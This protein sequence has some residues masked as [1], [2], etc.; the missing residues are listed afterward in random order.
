MIPERT[1]DASSARK[2]A[3]TR[4]RS[5]HLAACSGTSSS[6]GVTS[7]PTEPGAVTQPGSIGAIPAAGTPSG[8]AGTITYA[9]Q[10]GAVPNWILP[11]PAAAS[12]SVY[13]VF[14]FEWQ[15][16]PPMY[17]APNGST[18]TVDPSL[19]V[20]NPPTR[21]PPRR[22]QRTRPAGRSLTSPMRPMRPR[23]SPT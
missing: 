10:P 22:G 1:G 3:M 21:C 11:M 7:T 5:K 12:N 23:S 8:T 18:P 9:L 6:S 13:N 2:G 20:A 14:N 4:L 15:M 17:Y 19:S 16:W